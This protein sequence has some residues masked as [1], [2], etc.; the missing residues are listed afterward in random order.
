MKF[1]GRVLLVGLLVS[2]LATAATASTITGPARMITDV[3]LHNGGVLRGQLVDAQGIAVS[4][5]HVS[6]RHHGHVIATVQTDANGRFVVGGI[7]AGLHNIETATSNTTHRF[8]AP[9]T[10]PPSASSAALIV[11]NSDV[12]RANGVNG[13]IDAQDVAIIGIAGGALFWALDYNAPGS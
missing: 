7:R 1:G 4:G 9:G 6:I 12:V 13:G 10:A 11:P 8:W 2:Q 5:V 3:S